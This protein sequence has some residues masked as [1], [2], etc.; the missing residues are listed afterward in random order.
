[1]P[2]P[3]GEVLGGVL[4]PLP[5]TS[6][7]PPEPPPLPMPP[8]NG[9]AAGVVTRAGAIFLRP[10]HHP[11]TSPLLHLSARLVV[12]CEMTWAISLATARRWLLILGFRKTKHRKAMHIGHKHTGMALGRKRHITELFS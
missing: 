7:I 8:P 10:S 6:T 2:P 3:A 5:L 9:D 12:R 11:A 4:P 1:M